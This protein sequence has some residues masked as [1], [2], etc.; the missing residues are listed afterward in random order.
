MIRRLAAGLLLLPILFILGCESELPEGSVAQVGAALVPQSAFDDLKT[1]YEAAGR[2]PDEEKQ[3]DE[4]AKFEQ[5]LAEYLVML[6]TLRQTASDFG[7]S[8][9]DRDI[10][11]EIERIKGMFQGD[12]KR[13]EAALEAQ[14]LTFEQLKQSVRESLWIERMKAEVTKDVA[15]SENEVR[16]HYESHKAEYVEQEAREVRHILISPFRNLADGTVSSTAGEGEWEAARTEAEKVRNEIRNGADFISQ[17]EQYS[18]DDATSE[19]GGKLGAIIRGQMVPAFDEAV[20][21]IQKGDLSEPV[22]TRYGYHIIQVTDITPE[23]QIT[24]D[25]VKETIRTTLLNQKLTKTWEA[26][27]AGKVAELG[28]AYRD[29]YAPSGQSPGAELNRHLAPATTT[30]TE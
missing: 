26:W 11:E 15:V 25:Q 12:E 9:T 16:D 10:A 17:V 28:V 7:V 20:F 4:Y 1:A 24:Y 14:N 23:R 22:K 5:A 19:N 8:V 27:L 29:G 30:T 2:A 13:F 6:E 3:P 21:S 18:D